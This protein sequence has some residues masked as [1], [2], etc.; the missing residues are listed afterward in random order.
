[1]ANAVI[2][3]IQLALAVG[4]PWSRRIRLRQLTVAAPILGAGF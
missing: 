1:V 2:V 3:T 4:V